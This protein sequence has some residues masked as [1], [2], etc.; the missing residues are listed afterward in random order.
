MR[1]AVV[2]LALTL[3][4]A[5]AAQDPREERIWAVAEAAIKRQYDHWFKIGDYPRAIQLLRARYEL[6][7]SDYEG[8]TDL[9][10]M[11]E[12]VEAFDEA[13]AVYVRFRIEN[14][15]DPDA[16]FPQANFFFRRRAFARVPGLI[17]PTLDKNPH[18]NSYRILAHSFERMGLLRDSER[19]WSLYL[20]R[21]PN[22]DA[23][24][25][26]LARVRDKLGG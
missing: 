15:N 22:D 13:L 20:A 23:A 16:P 3:A 24:K 17:E 7:P 10:W 26:N 14:P 9:G 5:G 4:V 2:V 1:L 11:L 8:A 19:I 18:P 6:K 21:N 25:R 12:N